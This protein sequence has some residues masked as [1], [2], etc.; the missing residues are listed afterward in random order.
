MTKIHCR[1]ASANGFG[2]SSDLAL[3]KTLNTQCFKILK[4][5]SLA[6][7]LHVF[8]SATYSLSGLNAL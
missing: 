3:A 2:L 5:I 7:S 6:I 1:L 8:L 4:G